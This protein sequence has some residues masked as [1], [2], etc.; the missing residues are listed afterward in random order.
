MKAFDLAAIVKTEILPAVGKKIGAK[1]IHAIP[2]IDKVKVSVGV[3]KLARKGGSS[4]SMDETILAKV[5]KNLATITN[6]KARTHLSK[7][8]ISNF[9]LREGMPIG[10][11][12]TLRGPRALDFISKLVNV[13]L[14]RVRDFRGIPLKSFD[15]NGNYS[16]GLKDFT[17]F[18]E[19]RPE[20]AEF[21]HGLEIT[22][23]TTARSDSDAKALLTALGFPFQKD[24]SK[25]DAAEDA[26]KKALA[27]AQKAAAEAAKAAGLF[28]EEKPKVEPAP[29]A[30][31]PVSEKAKK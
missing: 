11:S 8:A 10:L 13:A 21:V 7:K 24:T 3:G 23:C 29:V 22:V 17:V 1:N 30:P 2:H 28:K 20:D 31:A 6:Q 18:P 15:G 5:A 19:V 27:D 16:L 12:V 4:N 25:S 14:P 26:A 9:K